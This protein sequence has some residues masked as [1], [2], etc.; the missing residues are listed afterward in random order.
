M[1]MA[2]VA[3]S[4]MT[5]AMVS[6]AFGFRRTE[7]PVMPVIRSPSWAPRARSPIATSISRSRPDVGARVTADYTGRFGFEVL[8][9]LAL[10]SSHRIAPPHQ[11]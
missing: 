10:L 4:W 3:R 1:F 8:D 7:G 11:A 6:A 2:F 5:G 9:A